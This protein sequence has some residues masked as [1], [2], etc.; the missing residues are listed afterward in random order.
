[1]GEPVL[2]SN[3]FHALTV[4]LTKRAADRACSAINGSAAHHPLNESPLDEAQ[5]RG[6]VSCFIQRIH[7]LADERAPEKIEVNDFVANL[8]R[9]NAEEARCCSGRESNGNDVAVDELF[10]KSKDVAVRTDNPGFAVSG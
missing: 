6:D 2:R 8:G 5:T 9:R 10:R 7:E 3:A 1:M 4:Q